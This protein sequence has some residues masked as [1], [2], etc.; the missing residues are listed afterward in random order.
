MQAKSAIPGQ[1]GESLESISQPRAHRRLAGFHIKDV[2]LGLVH[3]FVIDSNEEEP[4][5]RSADSIQA[6]WLE[7]QMTAS[8]SPW[9]LVT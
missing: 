3:L 9:K 1:D 6:Q 5:G 4:D 2:V 7:T 8:S